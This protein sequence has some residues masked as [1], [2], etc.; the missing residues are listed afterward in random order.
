MVT[1]TEGFFFTYQLTGAVMQQFSI[2]EELSDI[3]AEEPIVAVFSNIGVDRKDYSTTISS[4]LQGNPRTPAAKWLR[5]KGVHNTAVLKTDHPVPVDADHK[6]IDEQEVLDKD[7][8]PTSREIA[9]YV[10]YVRFAR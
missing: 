6:V 4:F 8:K 10:A 5:S 7:G 3:G 9:G 1:L 2:V